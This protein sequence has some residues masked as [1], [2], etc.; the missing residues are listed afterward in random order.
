MT[1][2]NVWQW[3]AL[4]L[5]VIAAIC[6][7]WGLWAVIWSDHPVTG[8]G[9]LQV[10]AASA[11][12]GAG[13]VAIGSQ[14]AAAAEARHV[15]AR[16]TERETS[17]LIRR[18]ALIHAVVTAPDPY[19]APTPCGVAVFVV[20][21]SEH[22]VTDVSVLLAGKQLLGEGYTGGLHGAPC[23]V[24]TTAMD[25]RDYSRNSTPGDE[26]GFVNLPSYSQEAALSALPANALAILQFTLPVEFTNVDP[27]QYVSILAFTDV[28]GRRW[29]CERG[30]QPRPAAEFDENGN[31]R[32]FRTTMPRPH[33][34]DYQDPSASQAVS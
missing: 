18:A 17:Q 10:A 24:T 27:R 22:V 16:Q 14:V 12:V 23:E 4:L 34:S 15:T 28:D 30:E 32:W 13:L 11:A 25:W 8:T 2:R 26:S 33:D 20:N 21:H 5:F 19:D 1:G 6:A 3:G 9:L 31:H 29:E 7:V